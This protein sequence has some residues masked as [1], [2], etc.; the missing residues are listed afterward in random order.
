LAARPP[1]VG[2]RGEH[3]E[4]VEPEG[5]LGVGGGPPGGVDGGQCHGDAE[6]VGE[7]VAGIGEQRER[8]GGKRGDGLD[9]HH[10]G[11][12]PGGPP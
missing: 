3:L 5:A 9:H 4:P 1:G 2:Q 12:Q 8:P 6:H 10:P 7:H 11:Q